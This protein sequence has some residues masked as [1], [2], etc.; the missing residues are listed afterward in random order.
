MFAS[1]PIATGSVVSREK[2][3][4]VGADTDD[5][6]PLHVQLARQVLVGGLATE[7]ARACF[8]ELHPVAL[9]AADAAFGEA[10]HGEVL[11]GLSRDGACSRER[12]LTTLLRVQFNCF[13]AGLFADQSL[14]NHSCRPNCVK[15]LFPG[16]E[17]SFVFATEDIAAGAEVTVSYLGIQ[18]R[19]WLSRSRAMREQHNFELPLPSLLGASD[20]PL[21]D[22]V[23]GQ[24]CEMELQMDAGHLSRQE[25]G[26]LLARLAAIVS[27]DHVAVARA[28]SEMVKCV[29]GARAMSVESA[30]TGLS[31][32]VAIATS[33]KPNSPAAADLAEDTE[34]LLGFL[35]ANGAKQ[36]YAAFPEQFGTYAKASASEYKAKKIKTAIRD[37]YGL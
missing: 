10:L 3:Y 19:S 16:V 32:G 23:G 12:A 33:T 7:E 27:P 36:L 20:P 15:L 26:E 2:P 14:I 11:E 8:E 9:T 21:T 29:V 34:T 22:E 4:F 24:V 31:S 1:C 6:E 25:C 13:R 17:G 35:L 37:L 28:H 18:E 30:L 5:R